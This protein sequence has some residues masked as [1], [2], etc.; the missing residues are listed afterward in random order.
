MQQRAECHDF[1]IVLDPPQ[2][3]DPDANSQDRTT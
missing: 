1:A 3:P 2:L